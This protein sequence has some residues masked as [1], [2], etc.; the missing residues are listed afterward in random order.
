MQRLNLI[1]V[2]LT[3][4][5]ATAKYHAIKYETNALDL[6]P[7]SDLTSEADLYHAEEQPS[8]MFDGKS[9]PTGKQDSDIGSLTG[10]FSKSARLFEYLKI[11]NC[12]RYYIVKQC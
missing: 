7:V 9:F 3:I 8:Q 4:L 10:K 5:W 12:I 2:S 1:I 6:S 11:K